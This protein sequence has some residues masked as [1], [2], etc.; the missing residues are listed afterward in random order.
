VRPGGLTGREHQVLELVAE[1]LTNA[2]IAARLGTTRRTV[3]AQVTSACAKLG[4]GT[5]AQAAAMAT[6]VHV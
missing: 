4:A 3:V 1:G 5:R 6:A 2:E